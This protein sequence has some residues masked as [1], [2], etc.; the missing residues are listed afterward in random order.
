M[1]LGPRTVVL[2]ASPALLLIAACTGSPASTAP[3]TP[4][5]A[6]SATTS[7]QVAS[8]SPTSPA[9][10]SEAVPACPSGDYK[11]TSFVV[12]GTK[13]VE[14][15][16]SGGAIGIE[17]D[18]GRYAIDFDSDHPITVTTEDD[19]GQLIVDGS[20]EGTYTGSSDALTFEVTTSS[21][22][23]TTKAGGKTSS[24]TMTQLASAL[25]LNGK[26]E[27]TCSGSTATLTAGLLTLQLQQDN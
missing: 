12:T 11:V 21:G 17:F 8:A 13:G 24:I 3:A 5:P 26:G 1:R 18:N 15:R 25:G 23:A 6:I 14:G 9:S 10:S 27:A 20:V 16:G 7:E 4:D 22:K 2:A 19:S